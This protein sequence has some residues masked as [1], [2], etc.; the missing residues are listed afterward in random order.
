MHIDVIAQELWFH[1]RPWILLGTGPS[2]D[3][4]DYEKYKD[5]NI[6]AVYNAAEASGH[7]DIHLISDEWQS[8]VK[9]DRND[10]TVTMYQPHLEKPIVVPSR[11]SRHI[12]TRILNK[13]HYPIGGDKIV[14][15]PYD[16]D[17]KQHPEN[18]S[19][20]GTI[21]RT[22]NTSSFAVMFLGMQGVKKI[23]TC[24]IDGGFGTSN[25]VDESYRKASLQDFTH[26]NAGVYGHARNFGIELIKL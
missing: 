22:S 6:I 23:Y 24:G 15:F 14:Y 8:I 4:F 18:Y 11:N 1:S 19:G 2:L 17:V 7:V 5:S 25:K 12:A 16:S 9:K 26:E 13:H 20:I 10:Y 21:F 3:T